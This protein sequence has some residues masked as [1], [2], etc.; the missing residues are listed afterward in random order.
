MHPLSSN[1]SHDPTRIQETQPKTLNPKVKTK[2]R[3]HQQVEP[4]SIS[5]SG[6]E[7]G[8]YTEAMANLPEVRQE[9]IT[10]IQDALQKGNYSVSSKDLADTLIKEISNHSP[11]PS[12]S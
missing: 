3:S 4:V 12:S 7:I 5:P 8:H 10:K 9:R 11:N 1:P 6:Q 2:S